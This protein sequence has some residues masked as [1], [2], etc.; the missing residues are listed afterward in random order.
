MTSVVYAILYGSPKKKGGRSGRGKPPPVPI[1]GS[2]SGDERRYLEENASVFAV[3]NGEQTMN[4]YRA[5]IDLFNRSPVLVKFFIV[6]SAIS[7]VIIMI[8]VGFCM[9]VNLCR[10][11]NTYMIT[12]ICMGFFLVLFGAATLYVSLKM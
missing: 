6:I 4:A 12:F 2:Y 8:P 7:L 3:S 9:I 1:L 10:D 11:W 5:A